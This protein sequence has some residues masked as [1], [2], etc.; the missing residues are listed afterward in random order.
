MSGLA[1]PLLSMALA[2]PVDPAKPVKEAGAP[3]PRGHSV[4]P[5]RPHC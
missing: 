2:L 4:S 5:S 3:G 1:R